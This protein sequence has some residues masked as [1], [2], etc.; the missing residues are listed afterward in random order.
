VFTEEDRHAEAQAEAEKQERKND[1]DAEVAEF[2]GQLEAIHGPVM[3]TE[4]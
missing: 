3:Q 4:T 2:V 1:F